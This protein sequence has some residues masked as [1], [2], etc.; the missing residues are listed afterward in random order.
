VNLRI[1]GLKE[2]KQLPSHSFLLPIGDDYNSRPVLETGKMAQDKAHIGGILD[3][4]RSEGEEVKRSHE[5]R[6]D[7]GSSGSQSWKG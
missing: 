6:R 7:Y 3:G 2:A 1:A 5:H 4:N